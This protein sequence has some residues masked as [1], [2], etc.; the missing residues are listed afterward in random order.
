MRCWCHGNF[1]FFVSFVNLRSAE[2]R[3]RRPHCIAYLFVFSSYLSLFLTIWIVWVLTLCFVNRD[4]KYNLNKNLKPVSAH[5]LPSYELEVPQRNYLAT[6]LRRTLSFLE[7][8]SGGLVSGH[9]AVG[10]YSVYQR[11][12]KRSRQRHYSILETS[13]HVFFPL[14]RR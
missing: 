3:G 9:S 7:F 14:A 11:H 2:D 13:S 10:L 8:A 4:R 5:S 12:Y 1:V 6:K